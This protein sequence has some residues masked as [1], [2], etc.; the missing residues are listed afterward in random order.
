MQRD[1]NIYVQIYRI[2][3]DFLF[4]MENFKNFI[5]SFIVLV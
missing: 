5:V 3:I 1:L 4:C 2:F